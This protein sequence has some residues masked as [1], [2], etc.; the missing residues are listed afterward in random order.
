L[1]L[2]SP[3][4]LAA[5]DGDAHVLSTLGI[6]GGGA[7]LVDFVISRRMAIRDKDLI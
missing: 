6:R 1:R 4:R 2:K 5:A 3:C 7:Y